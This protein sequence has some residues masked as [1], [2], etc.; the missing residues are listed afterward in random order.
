MFY[1]AHIQ[2]R[3]EGCDY[4][5]GCNQKFIP[6]PKATSLEEAETALLERYGHDDERVDKITIYSCPAE[7][8][9]VDVAGYR[10][11][12]QAARDEERERLNEAAERAQ[13]EALQTKYGKK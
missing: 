5:I 7:G 1:F 6:L 11:K 12:V 13:L 8:F 9:S 10:R 4:T 2:G 3:G